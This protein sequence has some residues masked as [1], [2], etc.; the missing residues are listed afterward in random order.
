MGGQLDFNFDPHNK[1]R[2]SDPDTSRRAALANLPLK[3]TQ[4]REILDIHLAY[5]AGLIDDELDQLT[6]IRLNSLTTRRSE[7]FLG[8]WLEDSGLQRKARTGIFQIVWRVT[9]KAKEATNE[10][11]I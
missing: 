7:L 10:Q 3:H 6:D 1:S 11:K 4:R 2:G 5:P 9:E 8:G